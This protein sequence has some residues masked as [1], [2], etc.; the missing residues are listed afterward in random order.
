[1]K[2]LPRLALPALLA[3]CLP[4]A[5]CQWDP[6]GHTVSVKAQYT[7]LKDQTVAVLVSV[8]RHILD[9]DAARDIGTAITRR[10][11]ANE[12]LKEQHVKIIPQG[13]VQAFVDENPYWALRQPTV[14]QKSLGV[15]RL[16][17]IDINEFRTHEEGS[18]GDLIQGV[19]NGHVR[20]LESD[21]CAG[22]HFAHDQPT[23]A[24]YPARRTS[25]EGVP[26][27]YKN[28]TISSA[29]ILL[30]N[31]FAHLAAGVFYDHT[32]DR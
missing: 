22:D 23:E 10:L 12:D 27:G 11:A 24:F 5:S 4:L 25:S 9:P 16:I 14:I 26:E 3:A 2:H 32:E 19:A 20:V 29:R 31:N 7:N 1:M 15:T 30:I 6:L 28:T 17:W 13:R 18:A 8:P 21:N